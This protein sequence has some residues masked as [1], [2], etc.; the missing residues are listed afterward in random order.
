MRAI[1]NFETEKHMF[2][3]I[4]GVFDKND[5]V[6]FEQWIVDDERRS[7]LLSEGDFTAISIKETDAY[8]IISQLIAKVNREDERTEARSQTERHCYDQPRIDETQIEEKTQS[9]PRRGRQLGTSF[10]Y[11]SSVTNSETFLKKMAKDVFKKWRSLRKESEL[12]RLTWDDD[13]A[14]ISK[15]YSRDIVEN[16]VDVEGSKFC[17]VSIEMDFSAE[18]KEEYAQLFFQELC[19]S[20]IA[21]LPLT[22][23]GYVGISASS[24]N[25][26]QNFVLVL[27]FNSRP[28][29]RR[30]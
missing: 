21:C 27:L 10:N 15:H 30:E 3:V 14:R 2:M 28:F 16:K 8:V 1:H 17:P 20:G 12:M 4:N 11:S 23:L 22:T 5:P 9:S 6:M 24:Y 25:H 26:G 13:L 18:H 19:R 29:N 7:I